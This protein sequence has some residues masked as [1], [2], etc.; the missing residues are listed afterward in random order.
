MSWSERKKESYEYWLPVF[1]ELRVDNPYFTIK[2]T[3]NGTFGLFDSEIQ[4]DKIFLE[5]VDDKVNFF[6][7]RKLYSFKVPANVSSIYQKG[8]NEMWLIPEAELEEIILT[9]EDVNKTNLSNT[10]DLKWSELTVRD[11]VSILYKK[12]VSKKDWINE[13][14]KTL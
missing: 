1:K 2:K 10:E 11:I 14:I 4:K 5:K 3:Y 12:P 6:E 7:D 8:A 13:L 9:I